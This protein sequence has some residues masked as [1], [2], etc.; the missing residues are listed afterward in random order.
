MEAIIKSVGGK[1]VDWNF[2]TECCGAAHSIAH[3]DI[4]EKLCKGII[5]NAQKHVADVIIVACPMCHSNL[6]MR[7]LNIIKH[8]PGHKPIPVLYLSQLIGL[9]M[10]ID[11]K[12]LGLGVHYI[13]TKPLLEKIKAADLPPEEKKAPPVPPV[14]NEKIKK[15]VEV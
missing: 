8:F 4:V 5:D 6:D 10:G 9:T 2:K 1:T 3:T 7:Q 12:R 14:S 11:E 13:S 15:G